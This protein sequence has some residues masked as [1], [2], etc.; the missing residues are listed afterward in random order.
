V[1]K[2]VMK[3]I[4]IVALLQDRKQ[5][6]ELLQ[7]RGMV[8]ISDLNDEALVKV[9]TDSRV[10]MF[11]K[12]INTAVAAKE[13]LSKYCPAKQS[14]LS[15]LNGRREISK[16]EF[17]SFA[18]QSSIYLDKCHKLI[19]L[20][21]AINEH[22]AAIVKIQTM[23]DSLKA[24][25]DLDM[26]MQYKGTKYTCCYVGTLPNQRAREDILQ[27]IAARKPELDLFH[28]EVVASYKEMTCIAVICHKS[29]A[30]ETLDV[31]RQIGFS[32]PSY[33]TDQ[34]PSQALRQFEQEID[35]YE[36]EIEGCIK[37]IESYAEEREKIELLIDYFSMRKDKYQALSRIGITKNTFV[38]SGYIPEKYA[39]VIVGELESKFTVAVT[40]STPAD[41]EDVPVLLENRDFAAGVESVTEMY[42]LPSKRDIDP[43]PVMAFFYYLLFGMMLSDAG[44]GVLMVAGTAIVL[45]K[46]N[47][48]GSLRK[49]LKMFFYCGISTIFWGA[50]FG[51]WFG[52]IVPIVCREF[53]GYN[54][55]SIALWF[56]PVADPIRLLLFS[57][58]IG[59]IHLFAGLAVS[60]KMAWDEGRK[61]DAILDTVPI[62]L[63]VLGAAPLGAG[64]LADVPPILAEIGKYLALAGVVLV[65]L[66]AG[67]SSKNIFARIGGGLYALYNIASG[68]FSDILSYSRLLALGLA[69]GSIA[70]VINL[71]GTMPKNLVVKGILLTVVF[72]VG[73]P[74]NMA[75]NLLGAYVHTNRLHF[76]E[77]FSK[78]YEGG[79]RAFNPLKANTKFIKLKEEIQK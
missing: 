6:L 67:R 42:A 48:E 4:E 27:D 50:L 24:W 58:G 34:V 49:T 8:E 47:V 28:L 55:P 15:M 46:F 79:G 78:F 72:I 2:L 13:I 1:A 33:L 56:E 12:C 76:V 57:F 68:Y 43:N 40:L 3:R 61:L 64:I 45:R 26:P 30:D 60:F 36:K 70:G 75:I 20:D 74:L 9:N 29:A 5:I 31:L 65:V 38:I 66:T 51:S 44:Y 53:F 21:K 7:Q 14:L 17:E 18:K 39:G 11:D 69:T 59:I 23:M 77:F 32:Y 35:K 19:E 10:L 22:R 25:A 63:I 52:D 16:G 71:M 41:D 73:H 62:Y 37:S 54:P